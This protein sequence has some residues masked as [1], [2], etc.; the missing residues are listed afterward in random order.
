MYM[1]IYYPRGQALRDVK[2][3]VDVADG[4]EG[5]DRRDAERWLTIQLILNALW[6]YVFFGRRR[7][8]WALLDSAALAGFLK[9]HIGRLRGSASRAARRPLP[10]SGSSPAN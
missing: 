7:I 8:G 9:A 6:S 2:V 1:E 5:P 4:A 3:T 10:A